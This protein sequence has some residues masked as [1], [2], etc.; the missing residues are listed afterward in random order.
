[1]NDTEMIAMQARKIME[2]E[3]DI[4]MAEDIIKRVKM[5]LVRIGGPLNDNCDGYTKEQLKPF[6]KIRDILDG[7]TD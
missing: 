3:A 5:K 2:L 7:C 1:M 6:F 4:A